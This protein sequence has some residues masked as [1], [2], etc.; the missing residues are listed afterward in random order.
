MCV[1]WQLAIPLQRTDMLFQGEYD[2]GMERR[3][4]NGEAE[5][6]MAS[7]GEGKHAIAEQGWQGGM[8]GNNKKNSKLPALCPLPL[9]APAVSPAMH[10][11]QWQ[12]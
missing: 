9:S 5:L 8:A 1:R 3:L 12:A 4:R 10:R 7:V 2:E 11:P 6:G